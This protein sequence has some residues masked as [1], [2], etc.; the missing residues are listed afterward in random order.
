MID[1]SIMAKIEIIMNQIY[2]NHYLRQSGIINII[3]YVANEH[4][5]QLYMLR[6]EVIIM[7]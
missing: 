2:Q 7:G 6:I 5:D 3:F 1:L 4:Q